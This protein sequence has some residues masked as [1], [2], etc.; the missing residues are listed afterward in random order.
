M[1]GAAARVVGGLGIEDLADRSDAGLSEMRFEA[2]EKSQC[3]GGVGRM[4]FEPGVNERPDEPGPD[5]SLMVCGVARAKIARV[6]MQ[7]PL[8][9]RLTKTVKQPDAVGSA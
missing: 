1:S 8:F 3:A 9:G 4:H 7:L 2:V 5:S 6:G